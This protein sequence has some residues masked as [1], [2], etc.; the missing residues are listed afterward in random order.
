MAHEFFKKDR[1]GIET[2]LF[3]SRWLLAPFFVALAFSL[4]VLLFKA[5]QHGL[6]LLETCFTAAESAV[7]LDDLEPDR[8]LTLT[9]S[10]VVLVIFSGYREFR[11]AARSGAPATRPEWMTAI[12]FGGLKIKLLS[13][14]VA[15]TAIQTCATI[16]DLDNTARPGAGMERRR[17][18]LLR[19]VRGAAGLSDRMVGQ[20]A[21]N[22]IRG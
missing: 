16:M 13:S 8:H 2:I 4:V 15:I 6:H 10:L 21:E 9:G 3:A 12:D 1:A 11:L 19:G 18:S 7:V 17:P 14:I 5:G 20:P 22:Q